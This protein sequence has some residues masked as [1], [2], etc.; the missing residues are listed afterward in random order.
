MGIIV[1][2][3]QEVEVN[4]GNNITTS[5]GTL[6]VGESIPQVTAGNPDIHI[7]VRIIL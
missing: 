3:Y 6:R 1:F 2:H 4:T 7:L 5:L